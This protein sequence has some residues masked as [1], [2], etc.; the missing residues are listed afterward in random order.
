MKIKQSMTI[1]VKAPRQKKLLQSIC[2]TAITKMKK[3]LGK[4]SG[5][6]ID[7]V[8][9]HTISIS[10]YNHLTGSSYIKLQKRIRSSKKKLN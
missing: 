7:F 3:Y 6:V 8:I 1:F 9:D 2:T 4:D 10:K 5:W